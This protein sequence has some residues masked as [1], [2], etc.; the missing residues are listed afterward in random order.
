MNKTL[1]PHETIFLTRLLCD[2][3]CNI[4]KAMDYVL[5]AY[6]GC[7][8]ASLKEDLREYRERP[9]DVARST[10]EDSDL[11]S[12]WARRFE[13]HMVK[14]YFAG[15][16]W[17]A[18]SG[19]LLPEV[20][21]PYEHIVRHPDSVLQSEEGRA[22]FLR[23][24]EE[25][26]GEFFPGSEILY[27]FVDFV[28]PEHLMEKN[29]KEVTALG[30]PALLRGSSP[31]L[32]IERVL[33]ERPHRYSL[34]SFY[35][36]EL[37]LNLPSDGKFEDALKETQLPPKVR[38]WFDILGKGD[39]RRWLSFISLQGYRFEEGKHWDF[40]REVIRMNIPL[41]IESSSPEAQ[42]KFVQILDQNPLSNTGSVHILV[43]VEEIGDVP[44]IS[45]ISEQTPMQVTALYE[46]SGNLT[47]VSTGMNPS[48]ASEE[49]YLRYFERPRG[50]FRFR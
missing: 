8:F 6:P 24:L 9:R 35:T 20:W 10:S 48:F 40:L 15:R 26:M 5:E 45:G 33:E 42:R 4:F 47:P 7:L 18:L 17:Q 37:R 38:D 13:D 14:M 2:S 49:M 43:N 31:H 27:R 32:V 1:T 25:V 50:T 41:K 12:S 23:L 29:M 39:A 36:N 34:L 19:Y 46:L 11:L 3:G 28:E 22:P 16:S 30:L 44:F 21:Q